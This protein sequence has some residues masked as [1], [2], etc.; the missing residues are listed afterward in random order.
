VE[1]FAMTRKMSFLLLA[2]VLTVG[3]CASHYAVRDPASG[4]TYYTRDVDRTG[5]SG[6]VKFKD[7]AT[8]ANVIIPQSE[9][10]ELSGDEYEAAIKRGK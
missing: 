3:G 6:S 2:A 9:V 5:A 7:E 8:G 1:V 4:N 10:R